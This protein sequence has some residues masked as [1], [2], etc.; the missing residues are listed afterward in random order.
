V[1]HGSR[2]ISINHET[3]IRLLG[4][5]TTILGSTLKPLVSSSKNRRRP[6]LDAG[7]GALFLSLPI[8]I[9]KVKILE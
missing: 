2:K 6:A 9:F 7:N 8:A 3:T 1:D 5:V 4:T